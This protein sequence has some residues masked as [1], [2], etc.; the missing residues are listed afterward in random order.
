M[1]LPHHIQ[2]LA[3]LALL[4]HEVS[5]HVHVG[6]CSFVPRLFPTC[7]FSVYFRECMWG[8]PGNEANVPPPRPS[9]SAG[10]LFCDSIASRLLMHS[11]TLLPHSRAVSRLFHIMLKKLPIMPFSNAAKC[12][13]LGH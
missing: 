10:I 1:N 2:S 8:E 7:I 6:T 3:A 4:Q 9:Q 11:I 12:S 5:L 13:L